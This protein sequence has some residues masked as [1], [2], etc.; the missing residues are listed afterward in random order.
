MR[1]STENDKN[2]LLETKEE[3]EL[4]ARSSLNN[5]TIKYK[6]NYSIEEKY[7]SYIFGNQNNFNYFNSMF[8]VFISIIEVCIAIDFPPI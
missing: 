7:I 2:L 4:R 3:T 6:L 5:S 8:D 1:Q